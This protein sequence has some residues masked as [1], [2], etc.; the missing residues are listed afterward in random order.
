MLANERQFLVNDLGITHRRIPICAI[1]SEI[2]FDTSLIMEELEKL[3][4]N[5]RSLKASQ[6]NAKLAETWVEGQVFPAIVAQFVGARRA[7][8]TGLEIVRSPTRC[9][10]CRT[11]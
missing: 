7:S 6:A 3:A 8:D 2:F 11:S 10:T 9:P 1:G 5:G 4:P